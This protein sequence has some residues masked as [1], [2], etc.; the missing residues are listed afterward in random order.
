LSFSRSVRANR[1]KQAT[2]FGAALVVAAGL[3]P[4]GSA[5]AAAPKTITKQFFGVT[6]H[7]P[8]AKGKTGWPKAPVG[9][10]RLWDTGVTWRQLEVRKG[11]WDWTTLDSIVKVAHE[12]GARPL[13]V[14]GQTPLFHASRPSIVGFYGGGA[15]TMPHLK[16]WRKYIAKLAQR[17][18]T[19]VDY[20]VWNEPNVIGM[21]RGTPHQMAK[22]T[23]AARGVLDDWAPKAKLV[24]PSFPVR[25]GQQQSS[26]SNY[27]AQSVGGRPV[28]SYIDA[29]SVNLYPLATATY[30]PEA[31]MT[32]LGTVR[33]ILSRR[34]VNKP[35][36]NTEI[37]Y[38]LKGDASKP[39]NIS[40]RRE[41]ANVTR[42]YVLNAAKGV[43][44]VYW[45]AWDGHGL[46]NT[47]TT[48]KNGA[49]LTKAGFAYKVVSDWLVGSKVTGCSISGGTYTCTATYSGG[50]KRIYWNPAGTA[51]VRAVASAS[52]VQMM[53]GDERK[54]SGGESLSVEYAPIL[55]RSKH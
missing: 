7:Q 5:E 16:A 42:T 45:Y 30:G 17:Y 22:L 49:K 12:H 24:A 41:A 3:V 39:V 21:W 1:A 10:I 46:T 8:A 9:A 19:K 29:V 52:S 55:V 23:A 53:L 26:L 31:S 27:F 36:W 6:D 2:L 51:S 33:G 34:G 32:L 54:L 50:V 40:R 4:A 13:L 28:A 38:G 20:Q 47:E 48:T 44:R 15:P 43:K 11:I 18:G 14:L 37:N 35:I 25:L